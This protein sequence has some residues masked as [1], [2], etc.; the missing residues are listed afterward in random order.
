MA[1]FMP[2]RAGKDELR[3]AGEHKLSEDE[4]NNIFT[5]AHSELKA[6]GFGFIKGDGYFTYNGV[7]EN[8]PEHI[9]YYIRHPFG[10]F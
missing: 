3:K 8:D 7:Q 9:F 1:V 5:D 10:R 2:F 4:A 6:K